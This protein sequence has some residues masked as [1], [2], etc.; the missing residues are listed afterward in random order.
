MTALTQV[1][2]VSGALSVYTLP[3]NLPFKGYYYRHCTEEEIA[4]LVTSGNAIGT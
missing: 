2:A 4:L 3:L 1:R